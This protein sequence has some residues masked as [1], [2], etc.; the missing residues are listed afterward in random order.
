[1]KSALWIV[2]WTVAPTLLAQD[3]PSLSVNVNVVSILATV[4][5]RDGRIV[6]DLTAE[7][8]ILTEDGVPQK[9]RYFAHD[10]DLPLTVG[11]LVDT[12][13]SQQGVLAQESQASS[14]FF[15]QVLREEKDQAFVVKFDTRVETLQ[16][17]TSSRNELAS[18]LNQLAIP[19][20]Y[21][22]LLYSAVRQSSE[23]TMEKQ[24]GRKALILLT[25]GVAYR[26]DTSI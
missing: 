19:E 18:A 14:A 23:E 10:S 6:K 7:D 17:L 9:I 1:M 20:D 22:T 11:L 2:F 15:N 12:S 21:A 26:D 5:D 4:H 16:G 13:R 25:D 24:A 8:F 3:V